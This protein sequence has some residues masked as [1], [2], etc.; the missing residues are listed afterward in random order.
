[1]GYSLIPIDPTQTWPDPNLLYPDLIRI[2]IWVMWV[3]EFDPNPNYPKPIPPKFG[4]GSDLRQCVRL[5]FMGLSSASSSLFLYILLCIFLHLRSPNASLNLRSI[6][7]ASF[8]NNRPC[9]PRTWEDLLVSFT[10][11]HPYPF[12]LPIHSPGKNHYA[13]LPLHS[14][15][16]MM[17]LLNTIYI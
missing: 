8:C 16:R 15:Q 10:L 5:I 17:H 11:H 12:I 9:K 3:L 2:R 1:M 13:G 4:L 7:C 14:G 6:G